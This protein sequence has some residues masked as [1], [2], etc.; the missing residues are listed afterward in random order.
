MS[1][2]LNEISVYINY[3]VY[4]IKVRLKTLIK[5]VNTNEFKSD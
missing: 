2:I 5:F 4:Y 1:Q 3:K